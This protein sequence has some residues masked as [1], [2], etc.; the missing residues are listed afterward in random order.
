MLSLLLFGREMVERVKVDL[1]YSTQMSE[2]HP[3]RYKPR[4]GF[5]QTLWT[6]RLP[7]ML[8]SPTSPPLRILEE[9]WPGPGEAGLYWGQL[10]VPWMASFRDDC[11]RRPGDGAAGPN[12][13]HLTHPHPRAPWW[14]SLPDL[15]PHQKEKIQG[16]TLPSVG[17]FQPGGSKGNLSLFV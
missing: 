11:I 7:R 16:Q 12:T 6:A 15:K 1:W 10:W 3:P 8:T 5:P 14:Y 13:W 4:V 17:C 2:R 9:Y